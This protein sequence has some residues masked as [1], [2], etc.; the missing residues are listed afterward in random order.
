MCACNN[1]KAGYSAEPWVIVL[2]GGRTKSYA[3]QPGAEAALS[4]YSGA[5]L[6]PRSDGQMIVAAAS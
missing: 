2:P 4:M 3:T 6:R 1:G 5:Y